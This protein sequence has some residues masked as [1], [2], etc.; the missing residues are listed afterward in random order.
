MSTTR[1]VIDSDLLFDAC[2][3][4]DIND[5][6]MGDITTDAR[7]CLC[8]LFPTRS[9]HDEFFEALAE[10]DADAAAALKRDSFAGQAHGK[11]TMLKPQFASLGGKRRVLTYCPS[12]AAPT[13]D[14]VVSWGR[15][16]AIG[17]W[18]DELAPGIAEPPPVNCA[19]EHAAPALDI[20][21][22]M[23]ARIEQ[24]EADGCHNVYADLWQAAGIEFGDSPDPRV[25]ER[26][27]RVLP[28]LHDDRAEFLDAR[29]VL[30]AAYA[31]LEVAAAEHAAGRGIEGEI[32]QDSSLLEGLFS[33]FDGGEAEPLAGRA[34]LLGVIDHAKTLIGGEG[35]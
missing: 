24:R 35:A 32:P 12:V 20:L 22:A 31:A 33:D 28:G 15:G 5:A 25:R 17:V 21:T 18:P 8:V 13:P 10:L 26:G 3:R 9:D 29:P 1:T 6:L 34:A 30:K 2:R 19:P 16:G 23:R 7:G 14:D 27:I 11:Q 4:A